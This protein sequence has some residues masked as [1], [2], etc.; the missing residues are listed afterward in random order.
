MDG[1]NSLHRLSEGTMMI[2]DQQRAALRTLSDACRSYVKITSPHLRRTI[3]A[4]LWHAVGLLDQLPCV[5][6]WVVGDRGYTGHALRQHIRDLGAHP[7]IPPRS[8]RRLPALDL[9]KPQPR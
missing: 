6:L 1:E 7:A 8:A 4:I 3:E 2:A 9:Q 5:P